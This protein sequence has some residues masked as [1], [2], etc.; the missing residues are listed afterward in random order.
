MEM[1]KPLGHAKSGK[2]WSVR[3]DK[4]VVDGRSPESRRRRQQNQPRTVLMTFDHGNTAQVFLLVCPQHFLATH[5][6]GN[7][8][9]PDEL[10]VR[11]YCSDNVGIHHMNKAFPAIPYGPPD[12]FIP[13]V[14]VEDWVTKREDADQLA[15]LSILHKKPKPPAE[16]SRHWNGPQDSGQPEEVGLISSRSHLDELGFNGSRGN[17]VAVGEVSEQR[18]RMLLDEGPIC[19]VERSAARPVQFSDVLLGEVRRKRV[20]IAILV[21]TEAEKPSL[22]G[23]PQSMTGNPFLHRQRARRCAVRSQHES[24]RQDKNTPRVVGR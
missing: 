19:R 13:C 16:P 22:D 3:E 4:S 24:W 17:L 20:A 21:E 6:S 14:Q 12:P 5:Q 1:T 8:L 10:G 2:P 7:H 18:E 15:V 11:R 23:V 9:A